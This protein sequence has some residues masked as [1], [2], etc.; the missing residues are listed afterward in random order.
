VALELV[1]E[2]IPMTPHE[3]A[4]PMGAAREAVAEKGWGKAKCSGTH[5]LD[6]SALY[7]V[8]WGWLGAGCPQFPLRESL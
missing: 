8:P 4:A 3:L 5:V 2:A 6:K 7:R 1:Q